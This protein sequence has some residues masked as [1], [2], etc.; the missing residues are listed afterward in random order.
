MFS[1]K[2]VNEKIYNDTKDEWESQISSF[3]GDILVTHYHR[4][5]KWA[6]SYIDGD[7]EAN[8]YLYAL[9]HK[10]K[11]SAVAFVE[12]SHAR[13]NS[14]APWLK[15][16][17][18]HVEPRLDTSENID[19]HLL[20]KVA[21]QAITET[22]GLTF[23]EYPSSQLKVYGTTPLNLDFLE[24][25]ASSCSLEDYRLDIKSQGNWLVINKS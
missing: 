24:G 13:P 15:V 14:N 12:L 1:F 2:E 18:I 23:K 7:R 21:S 8:T 11:E 5:L 22:L 19:L 10:N 20:A 4:Y 6:K 16:L 17:D 9:T 25:V 3:A